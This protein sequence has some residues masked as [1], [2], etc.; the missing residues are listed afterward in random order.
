MGRGIIYVVGHGP[1]SVDDS[2]KAS[3]C[4]DGIAT[5]KRYRKE[6]SA[7]ACLEYDLIG[8]Y[9]RRKVIY[10][11][12]LHRKYREREFQVKRVTMFLRVTPRLDRGKFAVQKM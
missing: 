7:C 11:L 5:R 8:I 10:F 12:R 3:D 4:Q 9:L 2:Q 6:Q 1:F